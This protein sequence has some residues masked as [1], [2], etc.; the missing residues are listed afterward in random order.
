LYL[1]MLLNGGMFKSKQLLNSTSFGVLMGYTEV[2]SFQN[3]TLG[4]GLTWYMHYFNNYIAHVHAGDFWN[5]A[6][7]INTVPSLNLGFWISVGTG[8]ATARDQISTDL[9]D[10]FFPLVN[11]S[12]R[13]V[14]TSS[15]AAKI[16]YPSFNPYIG[17]RRSRT[18]SDRLVSALAAG[19]IL[20]SYDSSKDQLVLSHIITFSGFGPDSFVDNN[21]TSQVKLYPYFI[22]SNKLP[23][24]Y[25]AAVEP[26]AGFQLL[27]PTDNSVA[28]LI[29]YGVADFILFVMMIIFFFISCCFKRD[30]HKHKKAK[31]G[32]CSRFM[33]F[34]TGNL[35]SL[36]FFLCSSVS[37]ILIGTT[38]ASL[39]FGYSTPYYVAT[40]LPIVCIGLF[41]S[42]FIWIIIIGCKKLYPNNLI[43]IYL[44][45]LAMEAATI[46]IFFLMGIVSPIL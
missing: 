18:T 26:I 42:N 16:P 43:H 30:K 19:I 44:I 4:M 13:E 3:E 11:I 39:T 12:A 31:L 14:I 17:T 38:S 25:A 21:L 7:L 27:S 28:I 15:N 34:L 1:L 32:C 6:S 37:I 5:F 10:Q 22:L 46:V 41:V 2:S 33:L 45:E 9:A 36:L 40:I 20:T 8:A 29:A 24:Q 23:L 35:S